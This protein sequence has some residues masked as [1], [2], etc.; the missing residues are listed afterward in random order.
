MARSARSSELETRTARLALAVRNKSYTARIGPGVRLGYRRRKTTGRW[1]V[2]VADGKGGNWL[3]GFA[4]ADD[5]EESNGC[6]VLTYWQA[7]EAARRLAQG[8][9]RSTTVDITK[10]ATIEVVLA[11]YENDLKARHGDVANARRVRGHLTPSLLAKPVALLTVRDLRQW[12]EGLNNPLRRGRK[13]EATA[14]KS[15]DFDKTLTAGSINRLCSAL[16]A[17]LN[18]AANIDERIVSRRAWEIGL[19]AIRDAVVSRNVILEAEAVRR[20]VEEARALDDNFGLLV[21]TAATTGARVSQLARLEVQDLQGER[22]DPRLMMPT[23][24][25]GRGEKKI[26]R[27]PVP[28]TEGLASGLRKAAGDRR[29]DSPLLLK[30]AFEATTK[31]LTDGDLRKV[32]KLEISEPWKRSDHTRLFQR[33]VQNAGLDPSEVT[34][35]AL[36][37]SNIVRHL[38]ANVPIRVVAT[39]H[40]TSIAMIERTYSRFIGDHSDALARRSLLDLSQSAFD[41]VVSIRGG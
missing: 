8:G 30:S 6:T 4:D 39:N 24:R 34:I 3:K 15:R 18:L 7:Q 36:R 21:E 10:P 38:L 22:L 5:F 35:N 19:Q 27:R 12:R 33:A 9:D 28:I 1:S 41:N 23:S 25:K 31:E 32:A 26:M 29:P 13:R 14:E 17:A 11:A 20:I 16:R 37:H 2:I 40:D